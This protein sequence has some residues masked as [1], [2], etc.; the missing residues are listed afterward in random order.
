MLETR[1]SLMQTIMQSAKRGWHIMK[2]GV[3]VTIFMLSLILI[4]TSMN[5]KA[6]A[7]HGGVS[8]AFGPGAP[9]ETS[10]PMTLKKGGFLVYE[11]VEVVPFEKFAFA[12]PTNI[13]RFTFTNTLFGYGLRND[14]TLYVSLPYT[15]KEQDTLGKS[16]FNIP[17]VF[18]A[19]VLPLLALIKTMPA[20]MTIAARTKIYFFM[21]T[22]WISPHPFSLMGRMRVGE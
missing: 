1:E 7:H 16:S 21:M 19:L 14:L 4:L 8:A 13:D 10:S 20:T 17:S 11:K 6:L 3:A 15:I 22:S 5:S 12:G 18:I 2:A 9:V